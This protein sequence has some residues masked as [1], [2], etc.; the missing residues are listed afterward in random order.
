MLLTCI[1]LP[2]LMIATGIFFRYRAPKNINRWFGY[3]T[4]RSMKNRDTW[5]F[6]QKYFASVFLVLGAIILPFTVAAMFFVMD[7]NDDAIVLFGT[8]VLIIQTIG[9][10]FSIIPIERALKREFD[11][12]G[13]RRN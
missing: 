1:L 12:N 13:N 5:E 6:A 11:D 9:I 10:I 2:I 4:S 3:R 7:G 8:V